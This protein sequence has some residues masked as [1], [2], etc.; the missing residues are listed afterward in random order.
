MLL[1]IMY[2]FDIVAS[3]Q[4]L[5]YLTLTFS[6]RQKAHK[7]ANSHSGTLSLYRFD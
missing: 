6:P 4:P 2:I 7:A 1:H 3:W 5:R